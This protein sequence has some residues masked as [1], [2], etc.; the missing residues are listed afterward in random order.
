M[1]QIWPE[2]PPGCGVADSWDGDRRKAG[3]EAM[4]GRMRVSMWRTGTCV[5]RAVDGHGSVLNVH[6]PMNGQ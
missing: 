3:R 5:L 6:Q 4:L 2:K 1:T